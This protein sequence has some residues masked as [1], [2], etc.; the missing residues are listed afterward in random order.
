[1]GISCRSQSRGSSGFR[2]SFCLDPREP[3]TV[4][5]GT[6]GICCPL[7][8]WVAVSGNALQMGRGLGTAET[9]LVA[10][11][12][13]QSS[14]GRV[15]MARAPSGDGG[16]LAAKPQTGCGL[17]TAETYVS[18]CSVLMAGFSWRRWVQF[19]AIIAFLNCLKGGHSFRS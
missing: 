17:G 7:R 12:S 16:R 3:R 11:F 9:N 19:Q 5:V 4:N 6:L 18:R 2:N 1:M 10:A 14:H 13:W 8:R 15:L